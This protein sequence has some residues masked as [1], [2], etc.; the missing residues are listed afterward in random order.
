MF[1]FIVLLFTGILAIVKF[2]FGIIAFIYA[3]TSAAKGFANDKRMDN[4]YEEN[5]KLRNENKKF[6]Y[7]IENTEATRYRELIRDKTK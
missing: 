1:G 4:L 2:V 5:K 3:C 6:R 7:K